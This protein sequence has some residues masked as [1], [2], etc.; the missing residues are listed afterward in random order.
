MVIE[1]VRGSGYVSDTAIDDV[2]LTS[3]EECKM[4]AIASQVDASGSYDDTNIS[5]I[6][7]YF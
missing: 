1:G 7:F 6:I 3:G 4:A 5:F 2:K